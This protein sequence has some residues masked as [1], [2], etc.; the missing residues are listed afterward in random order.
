MSNPINPFEKVQ[1]KEQEQFIDNVLNIIKYWHNESSSKT[2]SDRMSGTVFSILVLLDGENANSHGFSVKPL[3]HEDDVE[4]YCTEN[5]IVPEEMDDIDI[6]GNLH[7]LWCQ[8][9]IQKKI[10]DIFK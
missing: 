4:D 2:E 6:A 3:I 5:H 7:E 8:E 1:R 10:K 9:D